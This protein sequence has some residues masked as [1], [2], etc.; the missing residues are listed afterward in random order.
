M[1]YPLSN[2]SNWTVAF[3]VH[4]TRSIIFFPYMSDLSDNEKEPNMHQWHFLFQ[5]PYMTISCHI[6]YMNKDWLWRRNKCQAHAHQP[7]KFISFG[8]NMKNP[9]AEFQLHLNVMHIQSDSFVRYSKACNLL[10]D[11]IRILFDFLLQLDFV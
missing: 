4:K 9:V 3:L 2:N 11:L 6:W 10:A 1:V 8:Q 7:S 5:L